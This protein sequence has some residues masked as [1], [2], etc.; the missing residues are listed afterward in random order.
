[1]EDLADQIAHLC[2][3]KYNKLGKNGKPSEKEWTVLSGIVLKKKGQLTHFS[4][5]CYRHKMLRK[6][7]FN[8]YENI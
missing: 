2:L 8:K 3:E 6:I 5:S 1:M 7:R 4:S